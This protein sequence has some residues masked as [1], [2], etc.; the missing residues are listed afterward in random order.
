MMSAVIMFNYI[1]FG[2]EGVYEQAMKLFLAE[3]G[4]FANEHVRKFYLDPYDPCK[5]GGRAVGSQGQTGS[6]QGGEKRGGIIKTKFKDLTKNYATEEK[7]NFVHLFEAI[8]LDCEFSFGDKKQVAETFATEPKVHEKDYS[9]IR[10]LSKWTGGLMS[11][12]ISYAIIIREDDKSVTPA[13]QVIGVKG[14]SFTVWIPQSILLTTLK[15]IKMEEDVLHNLESFTVQNMRTESGGDIDKNSTNVME[16][17]GVLK[18]LSNGEQQ[19]LKQALACALQCHTIEPKQGEG[20]WQYLQ[21]WGQR[22]PKKDKGDLIAPSPTSK[23][24]TISTMKA[25]RRKRLDS[26]KW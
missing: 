23:P 15:A 6:N 12:D 10:K 3:Y 11:A 9:I 8:A 16:W 7:K 19:Q 1:P 17:L 2:E 5:L 22:R 24:K 14:S 25:E 13:R 18:N 26:E 21:R 20:V 4:E